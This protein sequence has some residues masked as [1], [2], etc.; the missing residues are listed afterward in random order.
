MFD[1]ST[2]AYVLPQVAVMMT[3]HRGDRLDQFETA[4]GSVEAQAGVAAVHVYLC[5]DGPLPV[6]HEDWLSAN[7]DRFHCV[8]RNPRCLGLA[9]S[10]NRLID[11]LGEEPF[12]FRMDGDDVSHAGRFAAQ[13]AYMNDHPTL[14]LVG[15]QV[16]DIDDDGTPLARRKYPVAQE[17]VVRSLTRVIPVLHPTFCMRRSILRDRKA[18]YP[19]AYLTEDLAFLVRLSELG[20]QIGNCPQTLFSWRTGQGFYRRR[21]SVRRGLTEAKWYARAVYKQHG[22]LSAGYV[23]PMLRLGLRMMPASLMRLVYQSSLRSR[24]SRTQGPTEA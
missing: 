15:C 16:V 23:Y 8:I 1:I 18:R 20:V 6:A 5:C 21:T 10:L 13:I 4:L 24:I 17:D 7:R 12:V 3:L 11:V 2:S 9:E 14:G 19:A 22:L